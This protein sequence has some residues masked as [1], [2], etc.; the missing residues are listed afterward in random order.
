MDPSVYNNTS[1]VTDSFNLMYEIQVSFCESFVSFDDRINFNDLISSNRSMLAIHIFC[2]IAVDAPDRFLGMNNK[3]N[4]TTARILAESFS[5]VLQNVIRL[6][7]Q[8]SAQGEGFE[9]FMPMSRRSSI[10]TVT[11]GPL[12]QPAPDP[13]PKS[14]AVESI[15]ALDDAGSVYTF[16]SNSIYTMESSRR[17]DAEFYPYEEHM[18]D[19]SYSTEALQN[20]GEGELPWDMAGSAICSGRWP[21]KEDEDH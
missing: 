21:L 7:N 9:N 1:A 6:R 10:N 11:Q 18:K 13:I 2:K 16:E 8:G 14:K 12:I 5:R 15:K 17:M 19:E 3:E 4:A 20:S